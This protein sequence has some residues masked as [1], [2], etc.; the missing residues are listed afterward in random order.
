MAKD[1]VIPDLAEA[2]SDQLY[3]A[4]DFLLAA[5]AELQEL[6]FFNVANLLNLEV[7]VVFLDTTSTYFEVEEP[8]DPDNTKLHLRRRGKSKDNHP[9]LPQVVIG[10][11]ITREGIPVRCWTWP[12]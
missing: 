11:A 2:T 9:E 7:D 5:D 12:R 4:M 10:F 8:D 1:V 3:R 6:V